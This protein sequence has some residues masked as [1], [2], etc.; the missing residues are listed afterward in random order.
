MSERFALGGVKDAVQYLVHPVLGPRLRA[1]TEAV[2]LHRD[3]RTAHQ[4]F[5]MPDEIKF[6]SSMTLFTHA[7]PEDLTFLQAIEAFYDGVEDSET[8]RRL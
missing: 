1:A 6:R 2:L 7:A 4:I 5:G 8:T 3:T